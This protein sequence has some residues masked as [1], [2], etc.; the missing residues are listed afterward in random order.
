MC[1]L[2]K[3]DLLSP[4]AVIFCDKGTKIVATPIDNPYKINS[5][6]VEFLFFRHNFA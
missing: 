4:E 2:K 1:S 6:F 5:I 3:D